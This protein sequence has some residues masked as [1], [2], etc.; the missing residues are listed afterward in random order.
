MTGL[1]PVTARGIVGAQKKLLS[2][3]DVLL[4]KTLANDKTFFTVT[5]CLKIQRL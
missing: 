4:P 1:N 5:I 2:D 3:Q